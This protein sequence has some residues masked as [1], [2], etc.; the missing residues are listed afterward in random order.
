[1]Y[2][3][4]HI[5]W[6]LFL[7]WNFVVKSIPLPLGG[8]SWIRVYSLSFDAASVAFSFR[9]VLGVKKNIVY[10]LIL[11]VLEKYPNGIFTRSP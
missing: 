4:Y 2:F 3:L 1:V 6:V 10:S 7:H 11:I 8:Y 9:L 5:F